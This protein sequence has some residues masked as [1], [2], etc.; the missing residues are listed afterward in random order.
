MPR[1]RSVQTKQDIEMRK[2]FFV[3]LFLMSLDASAAMASGQ[4][5]CKAAVEACL[6]SCTKVKTY[7][8]E[9]QCL[10]QCIDGKSLCDKFTGGK[11]D[12]RT[13]KS[14]TGA[15][16]T[17]NIPPVSSGTNTGGNTNAG[18]TLGA[19]GTSGSTPIKPA[20]SSSPGGGSPTSVSGGSG[21][22]NRKLQ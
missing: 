7:D 12:F 22:T 11:S 10:D 21:L 20:S 1:N 9:N 5:N 15:G 6:A 18:T 2:V 4:D 16:N 8:A 13:V 17:K 19:S 14:N 3:A